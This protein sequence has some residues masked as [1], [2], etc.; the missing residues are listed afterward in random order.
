MKI[1]M[2][3][4]HASP[5]AALGGVDA[6]GQNVHVAELAAG[7]CRLGHEVTVYTRREDAQ[8][9]PTVRT[10]QGYRVIG[11]PAGP[12][13]VLPKD[14]LLPH[15]GEFGE[16]LREQ[17]RVDR[18]DVVHAHFW[19]SGLAALAAARPA[20]IPVVQTFHALGV[21]KR[22]HQGAADTSPADRIHLE[23]GIAEQADR[24]IATCTDEV[25]ELARM[26]VPRSRTS[27]IPCGVRLEQFT[28]D[29]PSAAKS[30][31]HR[32]VSVGR[33]VPRKGFD[34][35]ITALTDLPDTE[36]VLVGGPDDGA[37][38]E[39]PEGKR[40]LALAGELGVRD[41]LHL[42]GQV[43]RT[44]VAP[45]LRSADVVVCTP[46][47]EPFG[48]TPLEAM[49]CGV[50]VVA[51]AV[52]GLIDTVVDGVTGRLIPARA[53]AKLAAAVQDLCST[54]GAAAQYGRA[55]LERVKARYSWDRI[56]ADTV[57]E[58]RRVA[59]AA[60]RA[61]DSAP[62]GSRTLDATERRAGRSTG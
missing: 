57:R 44:E 52:G 29:G 40:L 54:P 46:W 1:A 11:V 61:Q 47:Y 19:M 58:Y 26:G 39:D 34:T 17:W 13:R 32:M 23:Q 27:V 42:V 5:L 2:V 53:P 18:P 8:A 62:R 7:L 14:E 31:N 38:A 43:P 9:P 24:I 3:S 50:P 55:G 33:L 37:V 12:A 16:F 36:L 10:E 45:L 15:M 20:G 41:R 30:A 22:R 25:F 51:A 28:P 59:A 35:A 6:G 21:V 60:A 56:A 4:E 48:I 49:A